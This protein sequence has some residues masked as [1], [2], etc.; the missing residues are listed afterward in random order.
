MG[1]PKSMGV[2]HGGTWYQVALALR[3]LQS[4][5][6]F[7]NLPAL[8]RPNEAKDFVDKAVC[9]DAGIPVA[10]WIHTAWLKSL[11][12]QPWA[13]CVCAQLINSGIL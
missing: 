3:K 1:D 4:Q 10:T 6:S 9:W 8:D 12:A 5:V 13:V 7:F 11:V 2:Q